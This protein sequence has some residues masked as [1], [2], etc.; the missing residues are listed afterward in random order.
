M[1]ELLKPEKGWQKNTSANEYVFDYHLKGYP[2]VVKVLST[3]SV[4]RD[5][6]KNYGSEKIRV[7]AV[8]K[9]GLDE[10]ARIVGGLVRAYR[11]R[12][13]LTW[14]DLVKCAVITVMEQARRNYERDRRKR[15]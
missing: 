2:I 13:D 7:F 11:L 8:L 4:F 6:P 5:R 15:A 9:A 10:K 12:R 14:R 3:V 1:E